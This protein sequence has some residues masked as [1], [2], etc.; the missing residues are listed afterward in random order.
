MQELPPNKKN[1]A[2]PSIAPQFIFPSPA[3]R[4]P[5][6]AAPGAGVDGAATMAEMPE[7]RLRRGPRRFLSL[8][9]GPKLGWYPQHD[10][11]RFSTGALGFMMGFVCWYVFFCMFFFGV[12]SFFVLSLL[13]SGTLKWVAQEVYED[14]V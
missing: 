11:F 6:L 3:P 13:F 8:W 10:A 2:T 7:A 1:T 9:R 12:P 4:E 14:S 5:R